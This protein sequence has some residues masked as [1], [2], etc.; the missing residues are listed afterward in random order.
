MALKDEL[1]G[2]TG[3]CPSCGKPLAIPPAA[4]GE[5]KT[6]PEKKEKKAAEDKPAA[7]KAKPEDAKK[8]AAKPTEKGPEPP[9]PK[10]GEGRRCPN[11]GTILSKETVLCVRCG[12][13]VLTGAK[14]ATKVGG[15]GL[16][17]APAKLL[18]SGARL[19]VAAAIAGLLVLVGIK[20]STALKL[21][22]RAA[23]PEREVALAMK[24]I[25]EAQARFKRK[26]V[27]DQDGNGIGEYGLLAELVNEVRARN[28]KGNLTS[29]DGEL[30]FAFSTGGRDGDGSAS[31]WGYHFRMFLASTGKG[32]GDDKELAGTP[33]EPGEVLA[34]KALVA[35]QEK[36]FVCYAWPDARYV[37]G[38]HAFAVDQAGVV[39]STP[40]GT[41]TYE[42][43]DGPEA[44]AAYAEGWGAGEALGPGKGSDGNTWSEIPDPNSVSWRT[45]L[46]AVLLFDLSRPCVTPASVIRA[47]EVVDVEEKCRGAIAMQGSAKQ[48]EFQE[49]WRK[50]ESDYVQAAEKLGKDLWPE[51]TLARRYRMMHD[52]VKLVLDGGALE[53]QG[54]WD[55]A[56]TAY[57]TALD[58]VQN[59]VCIQKKLIALSEMQRK[60][61]SVKVKVATKGTQDLEK[62]LAGVRQL[63][64]TAE[65][66]GNPYGLLLI[67]DDYLGVEDYKAIHDDIKTRRARAEQ[68]IKSDAKAYPSLRVE[69]A[70][71]FDVVHLKGEKAPIKGTVT[72][73]DETSVKVQVTDE[74]GKTVTRLLLPGVVD[75][76]EKKEVSAQEIN[77]ERAEELYA[78]ALQCFGAGAYLDA[79]AALGKL[80]YYFADAA[81]NSDP[82]VQKDLAKRAL[83]EGAAPEKLSPPDLACE[84]VEGAEG[85]MCLVCCGRKRV[86]CPYCKGEGY[87]PEMGR[88]ATCDGTGK[89]KCSV[90]RGTCVRQGNCP[91]CDTRGTIEC[92]TCKG[93]GKINPYVKCEACNG[94]GRTD[95][96]CPQ[97]KGTGTDIRTRGPC[98]ACRGSGKV[99]CPQC[100]G[101]GNVV[102]S[103]EI[104]C[105]DCK[106]QGRMT[107]PGCGG[108]GRA[109]VKTRCAKCKGEAKF[110]CPK[111]KGVGRIGQKQCPECHGN[112]FIP[113]DACLGT[114]KPICRACNGTGK[115]TCP[116]CNGKG[117]SRLRC[118]HCDEKFTVECTACAGTGKRAKK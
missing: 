104:Q 48:A 59:R 34:D 76:I 85:S 109:P 57:Q 33:D 18:R 29:Q 68:T 6:E 45:R 118:K 46:V 69:K 3:K 28:P 113:C 114:G 43:A 8:P 75:R 17:L 31:R 44:G 61:E 13:N 83:K 65:K 23:V 20:I 96:R 56:R 116:T 50:A 81:V 110:P 89:I 74:D 22:K 103:K 99:P 93:K 88:C 102:S 38:V 80:K 82:A 42:G 105:P 62:R 35:L 27:V 84:A 117:Q 37:D 36:R 98:E 4:E 5:K 40:M 79:L 87:R 30:S 92:T 41:K 63:L 24:E 58:K 71:A 52:G 11:C 107:C 21:S 100:K 72:Q 77:K 1:G 97:C 7:P 94:T 14:G 15:K 64:D 2:K 91:T 66:S 60:A 111:C 26:A 90:C 70:A 53:S 51:K 47:P 39:Y 95:V 108:T 73:S 112:R 86:P 115:E 55:E 19:A 10:P 16:L 49:N 32:F 101:K 54:K 106:G 67:Y 78:H 12:T 25:S 9:K